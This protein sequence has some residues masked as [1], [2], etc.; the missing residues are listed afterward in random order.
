MGVPGGNPNINSGNVTRRELY[1]AVI[2]QS[3][4]LHEMERNI[5]RKL[6]QL[7]VTVG[8]QDER[9]THN[10]DEINRLRSKSNIWDIGNTIGMV[11]ATALGIHRQ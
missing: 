11:I 10:E 8:R 2:Q 1:D 9:I 5:T 3:K 4:E 7:C 6:D